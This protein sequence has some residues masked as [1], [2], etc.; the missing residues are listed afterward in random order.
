LG[1]V[2]LWDVTTG[3]RIVTVGDEF[4][5]ALAADI[6]GDQKWI[7]LGGPARLVKLYST[8][9][10]QLKHQLKKHTDWV[11]AL[12]FS[13]NSKLLATGDRNGGIH[14]WETASG[15]ELYSLKGHRG[16]I[17]A[18]SWRAD[19]ETLVSASEDA[20]LKLW[21]VKDEEQIRSWT[22]HAGGVLAAVC[23]PDGRIVSCG[24]DNQF[25]VWDANGGR[26]LGIRHTNDV[27]VRA[28]F[29]HDGKRVIGSDWLG[30]VWVKFVQFLFHIF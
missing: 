29:S 9:D 6:S 12:E 18:F 19:S 8:E 23:A 27:P 15:Q 11:T 30:N 5:T 28:A 14:V 13:P 1:L 4:D 24:R 25:V 20:T 3:E 22:G 10:G 17:T 21:K 2:A 26:K 16:A 7:A